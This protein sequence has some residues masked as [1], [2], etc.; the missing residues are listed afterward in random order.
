MVTVAVAEISPPPFSEPQKVPGSVQL[1]HR[2][3][4]VAS[5]LNLNLR[6]VVWAIGALLF[7]TPRE[8]DGACCAQ[9]RA[10]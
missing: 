4:N 6:P 9:P 8:A 1:M 2:G 3:R 5:F 7:T 10:W